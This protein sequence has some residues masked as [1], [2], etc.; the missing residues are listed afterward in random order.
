MRRVKNAVPESEI[1]YRFK[2]T[3]YLDKPDSTV[4]SK[5]LYDE[6]NDVTVV[7]VRRPYLYHLIAVLII[8]IGIVCYMNATAVSSNYLLK[9]HTYIAA[10]EGFVSLDIS[11]YET[12][13]GDM[14]LVLMLD[15]SEITE[16]V[17]I[18]PGE[19]VGNVK[20][21]TELKPGV[22]DCM[23]SS[24]VVGSFIPVWKKMAVELTVV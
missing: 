3:N 20:L 8:L 19:S 4:V 2:K 16:M 14:E 13:P 24:K 17:I 18:K 23:I 10:R 9:Y 1:V 7:E 15:G 21:T 12:N 5:Y 11:S 22:Y 6:S